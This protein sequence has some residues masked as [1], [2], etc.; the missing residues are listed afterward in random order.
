VLDGAGAY[1]ARNG[2]DLPP[3]PESRIIPPDPACVSDPILS[4][5][6]DEAGIGTMLWATGYKF[7]FGWIKA[8]TFDNKGS[9]LHQR[10]V[11]RE[12]GLFFV[13]LPWQTRRGSSFIW[14][15]WH[16]AKF[17][18][19]QID[20]QRGYLAYQGNAD[21]RVPEEVCPATAGMHHPDQL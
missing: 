9:P 17:I 10:G 12:P 5:D 3:E 1:S 6:L 2:L 4:L 7:D 19:D 11:S 21:I 18:A 14:G 13:G 15:V 16:D 8:N 20:I